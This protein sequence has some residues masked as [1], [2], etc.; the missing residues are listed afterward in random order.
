MD[1]T[2]RDSRAGR[3]AIRSA[4]RL[5]ILTLGAL[6][7]VGLTAGLSLDPATAQDR[8]DQPAG[9]KN[10]GLRYSHAAHQALK[11]D[12]SRCSDCHRLDDNYRASP[13]LTGND[14]QPCADSKCHFKE[15]FATKPKICRVCHEADQPWVKQKAVMFQ[16]LRSEF[17]GGGISHESHVSLVGKKGNAACKRCH[18][19]KYKGQHKPRTGGHSVCAPCHSKNAE[20]AM[21]DC[22]SCHALGGQVG[23]AR[24]APSEWNV[25]AR[26]DHQTHDSDPR[27]DRETAC[28]VC[29]RTIP[30]ATSLAEIQAPKMQYCDSCHNGEHAFK[31]TGFDCY[32][33]HG[34]E[35]DE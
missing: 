25:R 6:G 5:V 30:K 3:R 18:G 7:A 1:R 34:S 27:D 16:R 9:A 26:F 28:V 31:T 11:V 32:R 8:A 21:S 24:P 29:H 33:C 15:F 10:T 17:G 2:T 23:A 22:G 20:P 12:Q 35:A 4:G 14:H 19:D 13:P